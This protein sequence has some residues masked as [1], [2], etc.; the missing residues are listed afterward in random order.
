MLLYKLIA[1]CHP[2]DSNYWFCVW[3]VFDFQ[4]EQNDMDHLSS[5]HCNR[6][7]IHLTYPLWRGW[8]QNADAT[9]RTLE[10]VLCKAHHN[11]Y[12]TGHP[13]VTID[14]PCKRANVIK[15]NYSWPN[16]K[17]LFF[18]CN[19]L[20]WFCVACCLCVFNAIQTFTWHQI[21]FYGI[22]WESGGR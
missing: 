5:L 18:K 3:Q 8:I 17:T 20:F 21:Y 11:H 12:H 1:H 9:L 2:C 19:V 7:L 6:K 16:W 4:L 10:A 14:M 15:C 13:R 22:S